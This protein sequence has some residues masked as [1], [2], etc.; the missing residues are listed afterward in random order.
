MYLRRVTV[1][2]FRAAS[3]DPLECVLP[4]RFAVLA[5][6]NSAGK[7]TIIDS[8]VLAHRDVFPYTPRPSAATLAK[9]VTSRSI[10][11]EYGLE[12]GDSSP[13]GT[14]CESTVQLP[15][16]SVSLTTSMG[17]VSASASGSLGEGQLPVLYLSP[18][19]NPS[20]DLGGREARLIVELLRS[21]ALRD[22]G[23]KSL[24]DLRGLLRGL[25]SSVVTKWPVVD[26]EARVAVTLAELTDGVAGRI[27]Y[28]GTTSIDDTFLARVFE[29]LLATLGL[30]R[31]DSYRLETEGLGYANLLQLAVILA[32]I[33]D[34]TVVHTS[35]LDGRADGGDPDAPQATG[36]E[37]SDEALVELMNEANERRE[38]EDDTFFANVFTRSSCS[39][40]PKRI[41]THSSST[42]SSAT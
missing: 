15:T 34:L 23:D 17:R 31:A 36:D 21:Q 7:S 20:F 10:D 6:A 3:K 30:S 5:G 8:I 42:A 25:I 41:S 13:L 9:T 29:F 28:L 32:A 26:A 24:K 12:E 11:I 14:L 39:R 2:G 37:R 27:P 33:P 35:D 38:L 22:R 4:G 19:R 18:T 1:H 40:N 16:W